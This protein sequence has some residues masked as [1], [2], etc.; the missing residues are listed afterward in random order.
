VDTDMTRRSIDRIV[1]KT[2]RT[3]REA[4]AA[5]LERSPQGRLI[6]PTEVAHA[7]AF[8]CSDGAAS[9]NGEALVMDG[10]E[11]RR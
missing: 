1:E 7:V 9:I 8:L 3:E 5:I 2:G 10:G 4:R 6:A 11:L